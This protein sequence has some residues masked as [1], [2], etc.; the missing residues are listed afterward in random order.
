MAQQT[1]TQKGTTA[2]KH[3]AEAALATPKGKGQEVQGP[4]PEEM[5]NMIAEEA[6]RI[7]ER[8]GFVGDQ[9]LDDWLQAESTVNA[10]FG[11]KH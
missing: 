9:A 11:A 5:H 1:Q 10:Q 2:K 8:R 6:Y 3:A 7:A 4:M